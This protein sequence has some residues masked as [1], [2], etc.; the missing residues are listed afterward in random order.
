MTVRNAVSPQI[1]FVPASHGRH[2]ARPPQAVLR[3][4]LPLLALVAVLV[5][6]HRSWG[7][8]LLLFPLLLVVPG[9]LLLRALRVPGRAVASFPMYVPAASLA[10]LIVSSLAVDG[11]GPLVGVSQPLRTVPL[12]VGVELSCAGL[13][14]VSLRAPVSTAIPW[15]SLDAAGW[16]AAVLAAAHPAPGRGRGPPAEQ[17]PR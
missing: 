7:A 2:A 13:L 11:V 4:Y 6:L 15:R 17:R 8:E 1:P 12:L 14:A 5:A 3:A 16:P 9:V 10:V